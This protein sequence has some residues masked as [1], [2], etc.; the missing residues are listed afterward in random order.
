MATIMLDTDV[1]SYLT[2]NNRSKALP[3]QQHIAGHTITLSFISVGEQY[4]GFLKQISLGRWPAIKLSELESNLRLVTLVPYDIEVCRTYGDIKAT[5][6]NRGLTVA[7]N[8]MWIAACARR[9][10]LVLVTHNR[11]H[12]QNIPGL[13]IISAAP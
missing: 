6:E 5:T 7:S 13:S 10:S 4:T 8:D 11:R 12:F 9:H 3:Y 2:G 1:F